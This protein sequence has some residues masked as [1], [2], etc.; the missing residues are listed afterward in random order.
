[1]YRK[2]LT[3][4]F[5]LLLIPTFLSASPKRGKKVRHPDSYSAGAEERSR[6]QLE[7][8]RGREFRRW[9][10]IQRERTMAKRRMTYPRVAKA[11]KAKEI[12]ILRENKITR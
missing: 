6:K 9:V 12:K 7:E 10:A 1:M 4:A 8:E 3:W 5:C 11:P 2:T